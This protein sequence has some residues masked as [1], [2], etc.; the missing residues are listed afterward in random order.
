MNIPANELPFKTNEQIYDDDA[1]INEDLN[2]DDDNDE[3]EDFAMNLDYDDDDDNDDDDDDTDDSSVES[4]DSQ[5][6]RDIDVEMDKGIDEIFDEEQYYV[7]LA[8]S[9]LE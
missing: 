3:V 9:W 4:E 6:V 8:K 2:N 5:F 7:D 1:D